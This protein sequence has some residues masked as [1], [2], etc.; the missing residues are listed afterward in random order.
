MALVLNSNYSNQSEG[1]RYCF[2][3]DMEKILQSI[4]VHVDV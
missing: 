2:I 3:E 4:F 1:R